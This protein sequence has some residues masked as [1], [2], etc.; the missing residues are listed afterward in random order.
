MRSDEAVC[1]DLSCRGR[2]Y[3]TGQGKA[4]RRNSRRELTGS[5]GQNG[6]AK[7]RPHLG[8][9][10]TQQQTRASECQ[11]RCWRARLFSLE[12][13]FQD[14]LGEISTCGAAW[15]VVISPNPATSDVYVMD[16][17]GCRLMPFADVRFQAFVRH[18]TCPILLSVS[19]LRLRR[20]W[21]I[22][23]TR[24]PEGSSLCM[25]SPSCRLSIRR[26]N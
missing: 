23:V 12:W 25:K 7:C 17:C 8:W 15:Q 20:H 22:V 5:I 24:R 6:T 16:A 21:F 19:L 3:M 11:G 2:S 1:S 4:R 14:Q 18:K 10:Q 13:P 26:P 9:P